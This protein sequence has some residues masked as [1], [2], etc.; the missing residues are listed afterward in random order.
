MEERGDV[1]VLPT[2]EPHLVNALEGGEGFWKFPLC[3]IGLAQI[4]PGSG[5]VWVGVDDAPE[6]GFGVRVTEFALVKDAE[7]VVGGD[8]AGVHLAR[9]GQLAQGFVAFVGL[10]ERD[11]QVQM[12]GGKGLL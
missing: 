8:Q 7:V 9:R 2:A 4:K 3:E 6:R 1:E 5:F 12:V 10:E 11:A